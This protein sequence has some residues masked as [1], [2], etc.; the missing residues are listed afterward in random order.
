MKM[1]KRKFLANFCG[2]DTLQKDAY[3]IL[4]SDD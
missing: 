4:Y 1:A 3:G 2:V